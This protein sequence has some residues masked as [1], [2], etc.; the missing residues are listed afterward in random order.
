MP[1]PHSLDYKLW[2]KTFVLQ[3]DGEKWYVNTSLV[4]FLLLWVDA[5]IEHLLVHIGGLYVSFFATLSHSSIGLSYW[6]LRAIY[7]MGDLVSMSKIWI[8][9]FT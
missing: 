4:V 9:Y 7:V 2:S 5:Q 6:F 3:S 8:K 1:S